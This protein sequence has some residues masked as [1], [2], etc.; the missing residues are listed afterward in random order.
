[1]NYTQIACTLLRDFGNRAAA[2]RYAEMVAAQGG[3]NALDYKY[4]AESL[5]DSIGLADAIF[6]AGPL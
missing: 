1:M 6:L 4:A 2:I 3:R 5:R